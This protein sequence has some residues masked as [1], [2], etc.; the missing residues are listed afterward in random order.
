MWS[1]DS[2][3]GGTL[4]NAKRPY[5]CPDAERIREFAG[6]PHILVPPIVNGQKSCEPCGLNSERLLKVFR[7]GRG[8]VQNLRLI[9]VSRSEWTRFPH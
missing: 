5:L 1:R 3:S 9:L 4:K 7:M 2:W 6:L 8:A